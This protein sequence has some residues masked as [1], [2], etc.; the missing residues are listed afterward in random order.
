MI[1]LSHL[2]LTV[3]QN[4]QVVESVKVRSPSCGAREKHVPALKGEVYWLLNDNRA[5][6]GN[7][8]EIPGEVNANNMRL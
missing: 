1:Y 7:P 4:L 2:L 3:V 8:H 5:I 6:V